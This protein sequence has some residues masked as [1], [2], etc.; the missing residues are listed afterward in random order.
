M[1]STIKLYEHNQKAYDALLDMLGE[2]DRACVIKPT[3]TGKFVILAKMVQDNPDKRFLLLGT[4]D[5]M[6]N[7]QMAN[8][9]EI[10]PGFTPENLQFMT[11]SAAMMTARR[12]EE[13]SGYDV[14]VADEFHHCGAEEWG[15]G[16]T[17]I[18]DANENAKVVGFSATPIRYSDGG[19][20]MADEM[21]DG[22]VAYSMELEEAWLR[23][24]L[25]IPKY[26]TAFYEAPKELGRLAK[27]IAGIKDEMVMKR[28]QKKYENLR[29]SLTEAGG[30]RE[31]IA[32]HLKKRDAKVIVFCPRVAKLR[33]FM[34]LR[35]EWFGAV[36]SEIHVY[37]TVSADPYGS[38]DFQAFKDD[39]SDAL[40][41]LYCVN[42]LNEAVHV[43]GVDAIVMVRPTKSPTVFYQQLGRVL[44]SGGNRTPLVF[45][46]CN[47]FG[48]IVAAERIPKR[49][50]E[51]FK[52]LTGESEQ[53]PLACLLVCQS[54]I[55][56]DSRRDGTEPFNGRREPRWT[57][58]FDISS[59]GGAFGS[60]LQRA[61]VM[62]ET[63][64][65]S[66]MEIRMSLA[67][68]RTPRKRSRRRKHSYRRMGTRSM[69]R[70]MASA[71][72]STGL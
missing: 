69:T 67:N 30:V 16:V 28:F 48:S 26:V 5:Y 54:A 38:E 71:P 15:K 18:L 20:N 14:V 22:N 43:K 4:N 13:I 36:N 56:I 66:A 62:T 39:E 23:G 45:D 34:L 49:M 50:E 52:R 64:R 19:R 12:G 29:R 21:F 7:D 61:Q 65:I 8:L 57:G 55:F 40:K 2:C 53:L 3:G 33:E 10:A 6:F 31:A 60:V 44:S 11:Y 58:R 32:K 63:T 27:S 70:K 59:T 35:R 68:T 47:N 9:A 42:Q 24:I 51:T 46:F 41:V 17:H 25:P 37:K 1:S 72:S